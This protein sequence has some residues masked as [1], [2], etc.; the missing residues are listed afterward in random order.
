[1]AQPK[2]IDLLIQHLRDDCNIN[3]SGSLQERQL[4]NYGYYHGYKGYRFVRRA[5]DRIPY[6]DFSQIVAVI[7]FDSALKVALYPELMYLE[8]AIKSIVCNATIKDCADASFEYVFREKMND[9]H[10]STPITQKRL[11]LRNNVYRTIS[12]QYKNEK[13]VPIK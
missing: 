3:I 2:T 12:D 13:R 7:E 10:T 5:V 9:Q 6:T 1:M 11:I 4:I 8:S